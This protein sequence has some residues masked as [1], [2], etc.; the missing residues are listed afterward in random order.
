M[1]PKRPGHSEHVQTHV[2]GAL[3]V[4]TLT[5]PAAL[6]ALDDEMIEGMHAAL[7]RWADDDAVAAVW[8]QGGDRGLCAGGD[9]RAVREVALTGDLDR[10]MSFF[11]AEYALNQLIGDFGKPYVA[12]MDGIVMGGG[13]G[14]S[15]HGSHRLVTERTK[16]AMPETIIGFFPDVGALWW[17]SRAPGEL[18]IHL[19]LTGTTIDGVD[20]VAVGLADHVVSSDAQEQVYADLSRA[21]STL[22]ADDLA[23]WAPPAEHLID[24]AASGESSHLDSLRTWVDECYSGVDLAPIVEKLRSSPEPAAGQALELM[25]ERSPFSVAITLEAIRRAADM[26]LNEVLAQDAVLARSCIAHPDFA[27][28]VRAQLVDKDRSPAWATTH[29]SNID[30]ADVIAAFEAPV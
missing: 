3:G 23:A 25:E 14:I 17:L 9:V 5:R 27:E 19:A 8:V 26:S 4:I 30:Q 28:G 1:S 11:R 2:D 12:W 29:L 13:L 7:T 18:G 10:A 22:T 24:A 16:I 21:A 6:N 15:A 20:A